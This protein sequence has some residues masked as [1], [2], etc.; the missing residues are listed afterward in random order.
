[1]YIRGRGRGS[2][3]CA[4]CGVR[5]K[6]PSIL[7]KHVHL[8]TDLR[9]HHCA[10]CDVGFKTKGNL[11]KHLNSKVHL[12]RSAERQEGVLETADGTEARYSSL[13]AQTKNDANMNEDLTPVNS[14]NETSADLEADS[15][16]E[17]QHASSCEADVDNG[18]ERP[19]SNDKV[20]IVNNNIRLAVSGQKMM[21]TV[22]EPAAPEEREH[23]IA[24]VD[25]AASLLH[26]STNK[27][28]KSNVQPKLAP[29]L[30]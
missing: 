12:S 2:Y 27:R 4:T 23:S 30:G 1:V 15:G 24:D 13:D 5:C 25:A 17:L 8:H 21:E 10:I 14:A 29:A 3:V 26:M 28:T 22:R 19:S 20:E 16:C 11:S 6:K 7:R 18:N 9:P